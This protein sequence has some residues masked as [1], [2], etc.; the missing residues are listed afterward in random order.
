[1][2]DYDFIFYNKSI[3]III[4]YV[5]YVCSYEQKLEKKIN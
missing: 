3:N 5:E 1:M 2:F 4:T